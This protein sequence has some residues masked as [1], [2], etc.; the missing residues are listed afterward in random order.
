MTI[1]VEEFIKAG[2][3]TRFKSG[4]KLGKAI[5][6]KGGKSKSVKKSI[7]AKIRWLK[8]AG[9]TDKNAERLKDVLSNPELSV[10][11]IRLY[12]EKIQ[13]KVSDP[14]QMGVVVNQLIALHKLQHGEKK[15]IDIRSVN[16][17]LNADEAMTEKFM[18]DLVEHFGDDEK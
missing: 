1:P 11:D 8:E 5:A 7:G 3:P 4:S 13:K 6:T 2:K 10:M 17:N 9:L 15:Q 16:I 14:K 12:V 18:G